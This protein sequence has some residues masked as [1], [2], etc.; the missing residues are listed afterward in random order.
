MIYFLFFLNCFWLSALLIENVRAPLWLICFDPSHERLHSC[1]SSS[2]ESEN[3][4]IHSRQLYPSL[5]LCRSIFQL[6]LCFVVS[7]SLSVFAS[8]AAFSQ[9]RRSA[10]SQSLSARKQERKA[11]VYE[12]GA[13]RTTTSGLL[14]HLLYDNRAAENTLLG[15]APLRRSTSR[16]EAS[17]LRNTAQVSCDSTQPKPRSGSFCDL[18]ASAGGRNPFNGTHKQASRTP[19]STESSKQAVKKNRVGD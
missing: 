12:S 1:S 10:I 15:S 17:V 13:A 19:R 2:A 9:L 16:N 14:M 18:S 6:Q 11:K 8:S 5:L 7:L 3:E 4:W